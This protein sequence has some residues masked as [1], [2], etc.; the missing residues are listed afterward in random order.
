MCKTAAH[1]SE[2]APNI[3]ERK[4]FHRVTMAMEWGYHGKPTRREEDDD[5]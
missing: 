1:A 3:P 5:A 2:I 4:L